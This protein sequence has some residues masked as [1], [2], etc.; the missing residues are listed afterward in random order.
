M[1]H[2]FKFASLSILALLLLSFFSPLVNAQGWIPF[3]L[4][5]RF[6]DLY[7]Q[8][9]Q[10]PV[11]I[12]GNTA[13]L[14][15]RVYVRNGTSWSLQAEL[16]TTAGTFSVH[17][18]ALQ[19]NTAVIGDW[20]TA[21]QEYF[22]NVY[23]RSGTTWTKT[24]VI[25]SPFP[26]DL[27]FGSEI[28]LDGNTML[29][30]SVQH[31]IYGNESFDKGGVDVYVF[32]GTTWN[33]QTRLIPSEDVTRSA[34]YGFATAIKGDIAVIGATGYEF[35]GNG[36]ADG[37]VMSFRRTGTTWTQLNT[38]L[39]QQQTEYLGHS[40][41]FDGTTLIVGAPYEE[42]G[43]PSSAYLFTLNGSSWVQQAELT[44]TA[45][46]YFG[47]TVTIS[48]NTAFVGGLGSNV[49]RAPVRV[50]LRSGSSWTEMQVLTEADGTVFPGSNNFD[51][52]GTSF[53]SQDTI[54]A[55]NS[56]T[57]QLL[58]NGGFEAD[59]DQNKVPD[60]WS[61]KNTTKDER[62]CNKANEPA[63]AYSGSCAYFMKG[64]TPTGG[65]LVQNVNLSQF[66]LKAGDTL[67]LNGF[68]NKQSAGSVY[69]YLFVNYTN[70]PEE[71]R[72][73]IL[74][75]TTTGYKPVN[76][77]SITLKAVPTR[78]R[79]ELVNQTTSG[80]TWFDAMTLTATKSGQLQT[81][82]LPFDEQSQTESLIPLP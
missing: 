56:A 57:S 21:T 28:S 13:L 20:I 44:N 25:T 42:Q 16:P 64:G 51:F 32:D 54:F 36:M 39:P 46:Y 71:E 15:S 26:E 65:K 4:Q 19:G 31:V 6:T 49:L 79:V 82:D 58:V 48:G 67:R 3:T 61:R 38:I 30:S 53:I 23:T 1:R 66:N 14:R 52:D 34:G 10:I 75:Q 8:S 73:I 60:A 77:S 74:T 29:I 50:F 40:I 81:L 69:V 68:Y 18:V 24:Q 72:R 80:K 76:Q 62:R 9:G 55:Q 2:P 11:G 41:D 35:L 27:G 17:Q 78:V 47:N 22:V 63:I 43:N 37:A 33:Y 45:T 59:S 5:N 7:S 70:L 12:S